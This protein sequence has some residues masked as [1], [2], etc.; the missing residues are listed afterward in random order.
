MVDFA[1][2]FFCGGE[3]HIVISVN[4]YTAEGMT[5]TVAIQP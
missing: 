4:V 3:K 5:Q 2:M 1:S